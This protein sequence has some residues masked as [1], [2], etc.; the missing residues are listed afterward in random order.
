MIALDTNALIR[1]LTEDDPEQAKIVR[2]IILMAEENG[3]HI[4]VLS[5]VM[6]EVVWEFCVL[7]EHMRDGFETVF[8][9]GIDED[10]ARH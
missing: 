4:I 3:I 6:I 1:L 9:S 7:M 2:E 5:E 8:E 10:T